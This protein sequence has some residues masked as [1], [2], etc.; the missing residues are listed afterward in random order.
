MRLSGLIGKASHRDMQKIQII[1]AFLWKQATMAVLIS[2]VTIYSMY[3]RL[4][5]SSTLDLKF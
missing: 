3:L 5:L 4:N 1:G 2:A